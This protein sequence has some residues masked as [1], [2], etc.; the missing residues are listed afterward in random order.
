MLWVEPVQVSGFA[1]GLNQEGRDGSGPQSSA[2]SPPQHVGSDTF[3]QRSLG[4]RN[5]FPFHEG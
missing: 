1:S 3:A 5:R 2:P 4:L